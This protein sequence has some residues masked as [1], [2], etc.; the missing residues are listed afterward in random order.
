MRDCRGKRGQNGVATRGLEGLGAGLNTRGA[1]FNE[2]VNID[3]SGALFRRARRAEAHEVRRARAG[4]R[5][6]GSD[7]RAQTFGI[8]HTRACRPAANWVRRLRR[9]PVSRWDSDTL[10]ALCVR[11]VPT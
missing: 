10:K 5:H 11:R 1:R 3:H 8:R 7:I 6:K 9:T 4:L 2:R